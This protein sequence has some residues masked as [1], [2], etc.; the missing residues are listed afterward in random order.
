[1]GNYSEFDESYIPFV[2]ER[3]DART[4]QTSPSNFSNAINDTPNS[5][6]IEGSPNYTATTI[7]N[8]PSKKDSTEVSH[9]KK[10]A[11]PFSSVVMEVDTLYEWLQE[12]HS[13]SDYQDFFVNMD[14]AM[15]YIHDR[16][17]YITSF[18]LNQI[19]LLND[20]IHQVRF[21]M[22]EELPSNLNE[23]KELIRNNI[24][25]AAVLQ[26]GVY[27]KCLQYFTTEAMQ[28]LKQN[29]E[30]FATFLPPEDVPYYRGIVEKGAS[31]YYSSYVGERK[32]REL[33]DL[34]K[35]VSGMDSNAR[36]NFIPKSNYRAEDLIP[37]N[38]KANAVIYARL[39]HREAAFARA[40]I[41]PII[42]V[43]L[44]LAVVLL[45]YLFY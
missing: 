42:I 11:S 28:F 43:L 22:L 14:I 24:Y 17:F 6:T 45:S 1:M 10:S 40:L 12:Y 19:E 39:G 18:A 26:I 7:I 37:D 30:Q 41:Y 4:M 20:S 21:K 8:F 29:F 27:A 32:R 36:G 44:G 13:I 15:K 34:D 38:A 9:L 5:H 23:K 2:T 33:E 3:D 31:V 16:G 25:Y 35:A